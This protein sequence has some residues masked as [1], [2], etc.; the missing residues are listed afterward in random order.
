MVDVDDVREVVWLD[1]TRCGDPSSFTHISL[2]AVTL[3]IMDLTDPNDANWFAAGRDDP[4]ARCHIRVHNEDA[5]EQAIEAVRQ[6]YDAY[7]DS[8]DRVVRVTVTT[9]YNRWSA[10]TPPDVP[11]DPDRDLAWLEWGAVG[12]DPPVHPYYHK[13]GADG[14]HDPSPDD[15]LTTRQR[16]EDLAQRA[17]P[18][19]YVAEKEE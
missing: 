10:R 19:C 8:D 17:C 16:A 1:A 9:E 18:S 4:T 12:S 7:E 2:E 15:V 11:D 3:R 13:A 14:R 5:L 6:A